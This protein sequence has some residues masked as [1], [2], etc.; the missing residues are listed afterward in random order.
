MVASKIE[1][2]NEEHASLAAFAAALSHPARIAIIGFLQEKGEASSGMISEAMPLA[3]AT[4]SQHLGALK[5]AGLL[6]QRNCG[7]KICYRIN[8]EVVRNFCHSFQ[9]T[10][11]TVGE[12][13][14]PRESSCCEEDSENLNPT[15]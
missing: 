6:L 2:F 3:Q 11:G 5:R 15:K 14:Q 7:K 12:P 4:V 1:L 8:C 9:C 10:L 13:E